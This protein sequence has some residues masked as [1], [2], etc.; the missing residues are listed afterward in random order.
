MACRPHFSDSPSPVLSPFG[1]RK[2]EA[3]SQGFARRLSLVPPANVPISPR[4]QHRNRGHPR[5]VPASGQRCDA[6]KG[7]MALDP[8][9]ALGHSDY[10]PFLFAVVGED[11]VGLPLTVLTALTRLGLDPWQEAARL[12]DLPR[13]VAARALAAAIAGLPRPD[14]QGS[15]AESIA[16]RL[17]NWLPA[18]S[19]AAVPAVHAKR[20][21]G[22]RM[23]PENTKARRATVW[24]V[25]GGLLLASLL[26]TLYLQDDNHLEPDAQSERSSP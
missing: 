15:G 8:A 4:L 24:L 25:W 12:S 1:R 17:V 11:D 19:A 14:C 18:R 9:Y 13:D 7:D 20:I 10:N 2:R 16:A 6:L 3:L 26:F 23:G 5:H 22:S 21:E